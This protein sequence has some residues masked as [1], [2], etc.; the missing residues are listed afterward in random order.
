[1]PKT[2][3]FP[4]NATSSGVDVTWT[5][6][7]GTLSIGGWYDDFVGIE[8]ESIYLCDFFKKLGIGE[9]ELKRA[10]KDLNK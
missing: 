2:I 4:E 3:Y 6:T 8:H 7:S 9:K 1:M 5:K 10:I